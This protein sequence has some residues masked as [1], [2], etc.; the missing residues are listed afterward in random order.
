[1]IT[2]AGSTYW[3]ATD[4]A[5]ALGVAPHRVSDWRRRGQMP[6]PDLRLDAYRPLW[7]SETIA[8]WLDR[9]RAGRLAEMEAHYRHPR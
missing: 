1:M 3:T 5:A 7:R 2:I 4:V 8:P 6:E 9:M